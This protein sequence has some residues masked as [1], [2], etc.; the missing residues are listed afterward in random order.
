M[1][2]LSELLSLLRAVLF[3]ADV[4]GY[5]VLSWP[6]RVCVD[7]RAA[8]LLFSS[9]PAVH[10]L[11]ALTIWLLGAYIV[12]W[13]FDARGTGLQAP[14]LA[15]LLWLLPWLAGERRKSLRRILGGHWSRT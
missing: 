12:A 8:M 15:A 9:W 13:H 7:A 14:P 10:M 2:L 3:H 5:R 11:C 6:D 4:P 1:K